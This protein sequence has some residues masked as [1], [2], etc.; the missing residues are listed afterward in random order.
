MVTTSPTASPFSLVTTFKRR[1]INFKEVLSL[2][3]FSVQNR[4]NLAAD[5]SS[6]STFIRPLLSCAAEQSASL[7]R[8]CWY[9]IPLILPPSL[10]PPSLPPSLRLDRTRVYYLTIAGRFEELLH[11]YELIQ[12]RDGEPCRIYLKV[13]HSEMDP[14]EI[15]FV[16]W[17]SLKSEARRFL[18]KSDI[19]PSCESPWKLW[20]HS[21]SCWLFGT[22]WQ[23]RTQFC[24]PLFI[25]YIQPQVK[26][27]VTELDLQSLFWLH[28]L[29]CT[30]WLSW[31][32]AT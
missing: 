24:Q 8:C 20:R 22:N 28:V 9:I 32:H 4:P 23:R 19:S 14:A 26:Y 13:L 25:N 5:F 2:S 31:D 29:S 27:G 17:S 21:Y 6:R 7:Q 1:K 12:R 30:H 18:E 15:R 11:E 16:W 10:L 3:E